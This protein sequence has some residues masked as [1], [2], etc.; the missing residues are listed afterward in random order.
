MKLLQARRDLT[1]AFY[2]H[3]VSTQHWSVFIQ[4]VLITDV[5]NLFVFFVQSFL[6]PATIG[7]S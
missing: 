6:V 7:L 4:E 1:I 2:L 3:I 5:G